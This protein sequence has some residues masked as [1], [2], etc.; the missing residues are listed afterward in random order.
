MY[1]ILLVIE[2]FSDVFNVRKKL[3]D[4]GYRSSLDN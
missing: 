3:F 2:Y 4:P 1:Q